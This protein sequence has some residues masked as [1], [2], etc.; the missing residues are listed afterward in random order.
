MCAFT[1]LPRTPWQPRP[2]HRLPTAELTCQAG[3]DSC[4]ARPKYLSG[5]SG[6]PLGC[7]ALLYGCHKFECCCAQMYKPDPSSRYFHPLPPCKIRHVQMCCYRCLP[8]WNLLARASRY[9]T[10]DSP[11]LSLC[12]TAAKQGG[13]SAHAQGWT[14]RY[15]KEE[16]NVRA[17]WY[18]LAASSGHASN[19]GLPSG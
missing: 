11:L 8:A 6:S 18:S 15:C 3:P 4:P 17:C 12:N 13:P 16:V 14:S 1:C 9:C 10:V 5:R 7:Q 2:E 19:Q